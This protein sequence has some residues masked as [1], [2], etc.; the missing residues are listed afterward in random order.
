[1]N[2]ADLLYPSQNNQEIALIHRG[3]SYSYEKLHQKS[4]AFAQHWSSLGL[5]TGDKI[6]LIHPIDFDFYAMVLGAFKLGLVLVFP[7]HLQSKK[8]LKTAFQTSQCQYLICPAYI[9]WFLRLKMGRMYPKIT[10]LIPPKNPNE[11][12]FKSVDLT[13]DESALITF[14]SGSS[15][16]PKAANR[17]HRFLST[18]NR[19]LAEEIDIQPGEICY[20]SLPVVVLSLLSKGITVALPGKSN[21]HKLSSRQLAKE[22]N[23]SKA[24]H[25]ICA[26]DLIR[27]VYHQD[28]DFDQIYLGGSP[29]FPSDMKEIQQRFPEAVCKVVYGSTECEPISSYTF[30]AKNELPDSKG[31]LFVGSK[32]PALE[33]KIDPVY[34]E[35]GELWVSG[36]QVLPSY[37]NCPEAQKENKKIID[38]KLWHRTGDIGKLDGKNIYLYGR[39]NSVFQHEGKLISSFLMEHELQQIEGVEYG[40]ALKEENELF[41][42]IEKDRKA[43]KKALIQKLKSHFSFSFTP[44][45]VE[46]IF[47]DKRHNSKV[48]YEKMKDAI[49]A[50]KTSAWNVP[51]FLSALRL[52]A[53]P[54]LLYVAIKGWDILFISLFFACLF[55]DILDGFIAR[56]FKLSTPFGARLDSAA[57][58]GMFVAG[59]VGVLSLKW[60]ELEFVKYMILVQLGLFIIYNSTAWI[61]FGREASLHSYFNKAAGYLMGIFLLSL[62]FFEGP[63]FIGYIA[64]GASIIAHIEGIIIMFRLRKMRSNVK[65]LLWM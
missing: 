16:N 36:P 25:L 30:S 24:Q 17:T 62:F 42:L 57:D 5:K 52:L 21:F 33:I 12:I 9:Q 61:R 46:E 11:A 48:D 45:F 19:Y 40:T 60:E 41:I 35:I 31:G 6:M 2:V 28:V 18:Q 3:V 1:M 4:S 43:K 8:S 59:F 15:G 23:E 56:K 64:I 22:I 26:P 58:E 13:G 55:S 34:E 47:F 37:Y 50:H 7:E 53:I 49:R 20:V 44:V 29:V 63:V 14:T 65:G 38:G 51:N 39:K 27:K 54:F 32:H 10:H